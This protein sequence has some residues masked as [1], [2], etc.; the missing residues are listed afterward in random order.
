MKSKFF[1]ITVTAVAAAAATWFLKDHVSELFS[2]ASAAAASAN[3]TESSDDS[4]ETASSD[5]AAEANTTA[6]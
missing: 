6:N 5:D 4:A 1:K 3:E 2:S